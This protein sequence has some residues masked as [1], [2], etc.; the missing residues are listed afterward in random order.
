MAAEFDL[1]PLAPGDHAEAVAVITRAFLDDP[2]TT[3]LLRRRQ[4]ET[5][6]LLFGALVHDAFS[7]G[8]GWAL[9]SEESIIGVS[10]W[11]PPGKSPVPFHRQLRRLREWARLATIDPAGL[12]RAIR[13][14]EALDQMHPEEPH[15][16]LSIIAVDREHR[17]TG[18]GRRLIEAGLEPAHAA[19]L[20]VHLDTNRP[21][22]LPI[23][24]RLGFEVTQEVQPL[25]GS[26]PAWG[27]RADP[28]QAQN[29]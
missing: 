18:A 25:R 15:W 11:L 26:P 10:V 8:G 12:I 29:A 13:A 5:I 14:S 9:R 22:N 3:Y 19:G 1:A 7:H 16:F 4:P 24:E 28:A 27:M 20:P 6:S 23:Y 21:E 17:G 2:L